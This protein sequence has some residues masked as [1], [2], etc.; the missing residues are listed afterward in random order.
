[1]GEK[2]KALG[3]PTWA[4]KPYLDVKKQGD[5]EK[6]LAFSSIH[7]QNIISPFGVLPLPAGP[8][9]RVQRK[10]RL[11]GLSVPFNSILKRIRLG[12][13]K[14]NHSSFGKEWRLPQPHC[15]SSQGERKEGVPFVFLTKDRKLCW[16]PLV[17][18][19]FCFSQWELKRS[20]S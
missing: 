17:P 5:Y 3:Y 15:S 19:S 7:P 4:I 11:I 1:M 2:L 13:A 14:K 8:L 18:S 9:E 20:V 16:T 6:N 10:R 12:K